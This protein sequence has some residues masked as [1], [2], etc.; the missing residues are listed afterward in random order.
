MQL[1][2]SFDTDSP[3]S[4]VTAQTNMQLCIAEIQS[5]MLHNKLKLNGD[6]TKFL[7]FWP[8][9][10]CC[11]SDIFAAI[12]IGADT[13]NPG[14]EAR[15][16]GVLFDSNLDLNSHITNICKGANYQLYRIS[17]IKKYLTPGSLKI[18]VHLLVCSKIDYC[19]VL[20][21]DLLKYQL[22][23]LQLVMNSAARLVMSTIKYAHI[24]P[25]LGTLYWLPIEQWATFKVACLAYKSLHG[26]APSYLAQ[27]L[28]WYTLARSLCLSWEMTFRETL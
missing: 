7:H 5:W 14:S 6:K 16:L 23:R 27:L 24:T 11:H 9:Q 22:D 20:L 2:M 26:L 18:A 21:A 15:T 12:E 3:C 4:S 10:R 19:N 17:W 28:K 25:I 8:D 13:I 1:Y